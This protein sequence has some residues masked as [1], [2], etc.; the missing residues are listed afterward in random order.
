MRFMSFRGIINIFAVHLRHD[1]VEKEQVDRVLVLEEF[2]QC[3]FS[4][5]SLYD[6]IAV[7]DKYVTGKRSYCFIVLS[8]EDGLGSASDGLLSFITA[9]VL[10]ICADNICADEWQIYFK[11]CT[12]A[13]SA[14]DCNIT[15]VLLNNSID[16]GKP[17][18][19]SSAD[20]F[21]GKKRFKN[22]FF[23]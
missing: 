22:F 7:F 10:R 11:R 17:E 15:V 18:P 19:G 8:D 5:G 3:F 20:F 14:I 16:G 13:N 1:D 4:I 23:Y 2:L 6:C 21:C 12:L 9:Q